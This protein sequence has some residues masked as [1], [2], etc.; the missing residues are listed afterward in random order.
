MQHSCFL[1][2]KNLQVDGRFFKPTSTGAPKTNCAFG[3]GLDTFS[4]AEVYK[5]DKDTKCHAFLDLTLFKNTNFLV[6]LSIATQILKVSG[7]V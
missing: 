3:S 7:D 6:K 2:V 1:C 5:G 4:N